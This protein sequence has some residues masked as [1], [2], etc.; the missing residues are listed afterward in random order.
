VLRA[1]RHR[2]PDDEGT[3]AERRRIGDLPAQ[4]CILAQT[5]LSIVDLS[6]TGHQPMSSLDGRWR[7]IFNG[8]IYNHRELRADLQN[9]GE[10]FVGGSDTEVVLR[11]LVRWGERAVELFTGMFALALWDRATGR[12]LLARDRFGEKPLYF[13]YAADG[14][15]FVFASEIRALLASGVVDRFVSSR[16]VTTYL[17]TGSVSEPWTIVRNVW[18]FPPATVVQLQRGA[19][20][21]K[22]FWESPFNDEPTHSVKEGSAL[23]RDRLEAAVRCQLVADVPVGLF[24]SAGMDS[25]AIAVMAAAARYGVVRSFTVSLD[26][27]ALDEGALAAQVAR[28][29]G[30][31]HHDVHVSATEAIAR[32]PDA[33]AAL[34]QPSIDGLNT[35]LV[36]K[37]VRETGT[38]V[39]LS[40]VGGDELF[41]G[42]RMFRTAQ[43]WAT[44]NRFAGATGAGRFAQWAEQSSIPLPVSVRKALRLAGADRVSGDFYRQFRVL[45]SSEQ[46][47]RL[48][49]DA[50]R[51]PDDGAGYPV[52]L[53]EARSRCDRPT[54]TVSAVSQIELE[55]YLRNTLLRDTDAMSMAH[56]LEVRA[57]FLDHHVAGAAAQVRGADKIAGRMNKPL[58]AA[59]VSELPD[60]VTRRRKTGFRLPLDTWLRGPLRRWA[61][62]RL[63]DG[64]SRRPAPEAWRIWTLFLSGNRSVT[65]SRAWAM[66]VLSSWLRHHRIAAE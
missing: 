24:L 12:L 40:G 60:A 50:A 30:C 42:Y 8:E 63:E 16:G 4:T 14:S 51:N 46:I 37:G 29:I 23:V 11:A 59:A 52:W 56:G 43:R 22:R 2:G 1:L 55:G 32:V 36:S 6:P 7:L 38:V 28:Q 45:F 61:E 19:A 66:V 31:E 25:T 20:S 27:D 53:T 44:L 15:S 26:D 9:A 48:W 62:N 5:R 65:W 41:A 21:A 49:P 10:R 18:A 17:E 33:V 57:P 64:G 3:F 47:R 34:D 54:D 58:L 13:T 35:Y 39:A